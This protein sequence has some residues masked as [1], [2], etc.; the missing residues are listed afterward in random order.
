MAM[1]FVVRLL[2]NPSGK[3]LVWMIVDH[4]TKSVHFLQVTNTDTLGKLTRLY[5]KEIVR[6]YGVPKTIASNRDPRFTF[7]F[8]KSLQAAMGTRLRFSS[9][10]HL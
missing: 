7:H 3:N 4:L 1:G 9:T 5:V 10:Y 6:L 8:W 2:M